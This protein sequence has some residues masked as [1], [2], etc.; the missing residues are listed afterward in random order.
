MPANH[1]PRQLLA[2]VR[3]AFKNE[4]RD[5][6]Q[7]PILD[8]VILLAVPMML[9]IGLESVFALVDIF[10]VGRLGADAI[11]TVGLTES[12]VTLVYALSMGLAVGATAMIARRV[13]EKNPAGAARAAAQSILMAVVLSALLGVVGCAGAPRILEFMGA[14]IKV[15]EEGALFTRIM[16]GGNIVIFML[17]L[18]NGIFRGAGDANMA[19]RSLWL[20]SG[21][22][23]V[24]CPIG[25]HWFGLPGAAIATVIGRGAGV[26]YQV[27]HFSRRDVVV[28]MVR[29]DFF[30]DLK[31][32]RALSGIAWPA[33]L[34]FLI[35]SGSWIII[36]RLVAQVGGMAAA[37]GYQIAF[38]NFVFFILPAW[39]LANAA[40]TLVGQNLGAGA[41]ERARLSVITT[42]LISAMLMLVV[43]VGLM[44]APGTIIGFFTTDP[45]VARHGIEGLRVIGSGY[46]FYG[47]SMVLVQSLNGAGATKAP[48]WLNFVCFWLFQTPLAYGL[49]TQFG[50]RGAMAAVP[51]AHLLLMILAWRVFK[52]GKWQTVKV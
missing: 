30:P 11:A 47:V 8:A 44:V 41:P 24:L 42:M 15:I 46:V 10:F 3:R 7:G 48:T 17:F 16:L 28:R 6:T 5:Y 43:T 12:V 21:I 39:G 1:S 23:I 40:E 35:G 50:P 33:S 19:M 27:W 45:N 29:A 14:S 32:I 36:T 38:R 34:Q 9:E 26:C 18:L 25:I 49:A 52:K 51:I 31:I 2:V 13:G 22:N 4:A 37:A 20:A